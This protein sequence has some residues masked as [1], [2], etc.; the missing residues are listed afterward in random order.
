MEKFFYLLLF[1][2]FATILKAQPIFNNQTTN[3]DS[4]IVN[5]TESTLPLFK[6]KYAFSKLYI[7]FAG[8]Y[9]ASPSSAFGHLFILLKPQEPYNASILNW[10]VINFAADISNEN[11]TT[12]I[13]K[14]LFGGLKGKFKILPFHEK[15]RE[16]TFIESRPLW[17]FPF[18]ISKQEK[19]TLLTNLYLF[20]D[21]SFSYRFTNNNCAS[22]IKQL[23]KNQIKLPVTEQAFSVSPMDVIEH[24]KKNLETPY[25][26]ESVENYLIREMGTKPSTQKSIYRSHKENEILLTLLEWRY[27]RRKTHLT[28]SEKQQL[29][30]LRLRIA[31][32]KSI[33]I[34]I[35]TKNLTPFTTHALSQFGIGLSNKIGQHHPVHFSFRLGMHNFEDDYSVYP[36]HDYIEFG[37]IELNRRAGMTFLEK[38]WLFNQYSLI[39]YN[40]INNHTSWRFA[41]GGQKNWAL[42]KGIFEYGLYTSFGKTVHL[43]SKHLYF[44]YLFNTHFLKAYKGAFNLQYGPEIIT[45]YYFG[46][47]I[48][49]RLIL[50]TF[51]KNVK[52]NR[53]NYLL[54]YDINIPVFE[55]FFIKFKHSKT[56]YKH[57]F[58]LTIFSYL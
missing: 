58:E 45:R 25:F 50:N 19:D 21:K 28:N 30:D 8:P 9:P 41:I 38:L 13:I 4:T 16:Y 46:K 3:Y 32:G 44:S 31:K 2:L 23:L 47:S 7:V 33:P 14:G 26:V 35:L 18:S 27:A 36:K 51:L 49:L 53:Y 40:V 54:S 5:P 39:P 34:K 12:S 11:T 43:F 15:L 56:K 57:K 48:K 29:D 17:I 55:T 22:Q 6:Q 37:K 52:F 42:K 24:F 1:F 10:P 20:K